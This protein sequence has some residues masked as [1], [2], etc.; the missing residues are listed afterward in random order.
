MC[1]RQHTLC[2]GRRALE[3]IPVG[4]QLPWAR[5]TLNIEA[6]S[7]LALLTVCEVHELFDCHLALYYTVQRQ[8]APLLVLPDVQIPQSKHFI[9]S[10]GQNHKYRHLGCQ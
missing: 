8:S 10:Y 6:Y 5:I 3:C 1:L 9:Y 7:G 2:L 4:R